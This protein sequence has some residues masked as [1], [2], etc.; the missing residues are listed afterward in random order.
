[1]V[2]GSVFNV[3]RLTL[4]FKEM[5]NGMSFFIC[6]WNNY[7]IGNHCVWSS[8]A[9]VSMYREMSVGQGSHKYIFRSVTDG[10]TPIAQSIQDG[11]LNNYVWISLCD[12][13]KRAVVRLLATRLKYV[14][15]SG[16]GR[17]AWKLYVLFGIAFRYWPQSIVR[18]KTSFRHLKKLYHLPPIPTILVC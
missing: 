17:N 5:G 9:V 11:Q 14:L 18:N 3:K 16:P 15:D 8:I 13:L 2:T 4:I 1:M 7:S 12:P 10:F 6:R